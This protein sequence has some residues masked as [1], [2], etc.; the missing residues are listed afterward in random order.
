[1]ITKYDT[2]Y[3]DTCSLWT[4]GFSIKS[5]DKIK[6]RSIRDI[7]NSLET[8]IQ[9]TP[10]IEIVPEV[11]EEL[12]P[13]FDKF[14]YLERRLVSAKNLGNFKSKKRDEFYS[15]YRKNKDILKK[16]KR[17]INDVKKKTEKTETSKLFPDIFRI[18]NFLATNHT[19]IKEKDPNNPNF[20]DEI[21]ISYVVQELIERGN[22]IAIVSRDFDLYHL[23]TNSIESLRF[24]DFIPYNIP[25]IE[26][27][28]KGQIDLFIGSVDK[29]ELVYSTRVNLPPH[30]T[31]FVPKLN[32]DENVKSMYGM[33]KNFW[34]QYA[35]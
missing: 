22:K 32:T 25:L 15:K 34:E 11:Y 4:Q 29:N 12:R 8:L 35:Y 2:I 33:I 21:L 30:Y 26:Q 28:N 23:L 3:L 9:T 31:R 19:N 27:L 10:Q 17:L 6:F 7:S 24:K 18:M 13:I 16:Y 1:M 5:F 14:E 20:T